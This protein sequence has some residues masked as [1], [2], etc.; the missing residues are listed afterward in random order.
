M[1]TE[2]PHILG[3]TIERAIAPL[4]GK[5][6]WTC[7]RAADLA[8]F[9]FGERRE[10]TDLRGNKI[11]VGEYALHVQCAWRIARAD[12]VVVGNADMYYPPDLTAEE[13]PPGFEWDKGPNRQDKLLSLL[14]ED[15]KR[16][17][18]V[19]TVNVGS[20]GRLLITMDEGLSLDV[21]PNSSLS[22]EYWRLFK[23]RSDDP[24]FV[25]TGRG[26]SRE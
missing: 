23:P 5:V 4:Q 18:R 11:N 3:P 9:Q 12:Q 25:F 16:Q 22:G 14:F 8:A 1:P 15:G 21:V 13:I 17:F 10:T 26:V 24:H 20:G 19:R 2:A 6:L 7:T